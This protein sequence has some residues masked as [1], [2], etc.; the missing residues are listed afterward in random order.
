[1]MMADALS[2][3]HEAEC[4]IL[5]SISCSNR[6]LPSPGTQAGISQEKAGNFS[7]G[8]TELGPTS[9]PAVSLLPEPASEGTELL[10]SPRA[11]AAPA[12]SECS[13]SFR[14]GHCAGNAAPT[15]LSPPGRGSGEGLFWGVPRHKPSQAQRLLLLFA[16]PSSGKQHVLSVIPHLAALRFQYGSQDNA[17]PPFPPPP[18]AQPQPDQH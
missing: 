4:L 3:L 7:A 9:S 15:Q 8:C 14:M 5:L 10:S 11:T 6:N 13:Q 2:Q 17:G 1:M 18:Q 12:P 16:I